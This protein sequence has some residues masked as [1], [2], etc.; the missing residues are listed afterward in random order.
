MSTRQQ[1]N[2]QPSHQDEEGDDIVPYDPYT[3]SQESSS[4]SQYAPPRQFDPSTTAPNVYQHN[5]R[6]QTPLPHSS[7]H[8]PV[9]FD[10][11]CGGHAISH[12]PRNIDIPQAVCPVSWSDALYNAG[13]WNVISTQPIGYQPI[14]FATTTARAIR[15]GYTRPAESRKESK[16]LSSVHGRFRASIRPQATYAYSQ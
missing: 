4:P 2:N 13:S 7:S 10:P 8:S 11:F 12:L 9:R 5:T 14:F 15:F 16:R 6:A 1:F 3:R